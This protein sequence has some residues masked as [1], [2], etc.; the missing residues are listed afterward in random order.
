VPPVPAPAPDLPDGTELVSRYSLIYPGDLREVIEPPVVLYVQGQLPAEPAVAIG[1]A[2][3]P[4]AQG[5]EIARSAALAA[6]AQRL[7]VVVLLT[8]GVGI[9]A[10]RPA[11]TEAHASLDVRADSR[12]P[13]AEVARHAHPTSSRS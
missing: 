3:H 1:G 13:D 4:S 12:S 8:D 7:P 10:S 6:V 5:V 2:E 11:T 9:V